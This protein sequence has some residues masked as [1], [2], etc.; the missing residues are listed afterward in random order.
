[1]NRKIRRFLEKKTPNATS[2]VPDIKYDVIMSQ[3]LEGVVK[4]ILTEIEL[5]QIEE[6][7]N[8][9][10]KKTDNSIHIRVRIDREDVIIPQGYKDYAQKNNIRLFDF[11]LDRWFKNLK[12]YETYFEVEVLFDNVI[13]DKIKIPYA[14]MVSIKNEA[15]HFS[16]NLE[17]YFQ[18]DEEEKINV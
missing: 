9:P 1:M 16:L 18:N 11:I 13:W 12:V 10:I 17:P 7:I 15:S 4:K 6:N 14:S 3:A 8:T 5:Q 2:N